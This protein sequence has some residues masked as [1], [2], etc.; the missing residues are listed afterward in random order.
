[1]FPKSVPPVAESSVRAVAISWR[2]PMGRTST[3]ANPLVTNQPTHQV[4]RSSR[5]ENRT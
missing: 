3:D 4:S 2:S 5:P 1:M